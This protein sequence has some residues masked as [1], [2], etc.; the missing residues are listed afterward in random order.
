MKEATILILLL[1]HLM[2][3]EGAKTEKLIVILTNVE[4][5]TNTRYLN[6]SVTLKRYNVA[7]YASFNMSITSLAKFNTLTLQSSYYV[8][9]GMM[10]NLL[11]DS[12]IDLCAFLHRPNERLV[13]MVFDNLKRHGQMPRG[14]PVEPT[15][16]TFVNITLNHVHLPV[17]LPEANF[18]LVVKCWQGLG[19]IL[20]FD[21][22]WYG[23]LKKVRTNN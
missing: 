22:R 15:S 16:L 13:K 10:E 4:I 19:K 1:A 9:S 7:P 14:C 12:K 8:H 3:V 2:L 6:S 18:K 20:I 11:Y 5:T 21:S 17:Y 23:R